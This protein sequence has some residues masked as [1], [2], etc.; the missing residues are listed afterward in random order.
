MTAKESAIQTEGNINLVLN[1][2]DRQRVP[3]PILKQDSHSSGIVL[4]RFR[5][6]LSCKFCQKL[7][8]DPVLSRV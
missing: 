5:N 6:E 2:Y 3:H 1:R 4:E 7:L 8:I